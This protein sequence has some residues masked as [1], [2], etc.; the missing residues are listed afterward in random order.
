MLRCCGGGLRSTYWEGGELPLDDFVA[1]FG[2]GPVVGGV[3]RR[4]N[5]HAGIA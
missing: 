2:N 5:F 4:V 3:G 1:V